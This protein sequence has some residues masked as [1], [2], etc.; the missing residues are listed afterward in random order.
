[1]EEKINN[2]I[3]LQ[4]TIGIFGLI[5]TG[6]GIW[7]ILQ[8]PTIILPA[9]FLVVLL[10]PIAFYVLLP[11]SVCTKT[12]L[13]SRWHTLT[14]TALFITITCV[15]FFASQYHYMLNYDIIIPD[16]YVSEVKLIL[17]NDEKNEF[18]V[19]S[20]GIGYINQNTFT[21]GFNPTI[22]REGHNITNQITGYNTGEYVSDDLSLKFVSFIIP[23][24]KDSFP[25]I[26]FDSLIK[27]KA[28][29]LKRVKRK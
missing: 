8:T 10:L 28:I 23:R 13:K 25:S 12:L 4:I 18:K 16:S 11:L 3:E 1:M 14:F 22:I 9:Y 29:D 2:Q 19:N 17:S 7:T 21:N 24:K 26:D 6:I 27:L 5:S 15:T 20:Y